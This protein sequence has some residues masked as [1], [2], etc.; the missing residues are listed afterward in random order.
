M[1]RPLRLRAGMGTRPWLVAFVVVFGSG[2]ACG[3]SGSGDD[4]TVPEAPATANLGWGLGAKADADG[5]P[6]AAELCWP[7]EQAE[8]MRAAL[9][10][11]DGVL[12]A[13]SPWVTPKGNEKFEEKRVRFRTVGDMTCTGAVE[14]TASTIEEIIEEIAAARVTERGGR[15]DDKR[16]ETAMEDRKKDGYF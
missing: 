2:V 16:S 5:C 11:R 10:A 9:R 13:R 14:S 4:D 6:L 12:L 3:G 8:S 7:T 1:A 15:A